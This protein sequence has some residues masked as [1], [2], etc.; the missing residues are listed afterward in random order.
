MPYLGA[1][2]CSRYVY[3]TS[4]EDIRAQV[5][6]RNLYSWTVN[7]SKSQGLRKHLVT[8]RRYVRSSEYDCTMVQIGGNRANTEHVYQT[9][10]DYEF[11]LFAI[12]LNPLL[13]TFDPLPTLHTQQS[14]I[15]NQQ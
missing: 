10:K 1:A 2:S 6:I 9:R 15:S 4:S 12:P 11:P 3:D 5:S 8:S 14:A 7:F 13:S